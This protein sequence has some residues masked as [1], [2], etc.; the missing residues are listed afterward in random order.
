MSELGCLVT[1]L[2]RLAFG[3]LA[4]RWCIVPTSLGSSGMRPRPEVILSRRGCSV[5]YRIVSCRPRTHHAVHCMAS[6]LGTAPWLSELDCLVTTVPVWLLKTLH[7]GASSP[8]SLGSS[9]MRPRPELIH[10]R[11]GCSL[12]C[13]ADL[14]RITPSIAWLARWGPHR[15]CRSLIVS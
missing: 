10:S 8:P 1:I 11:R 12:S 9:G 6:T 14:A 5:S 4:A 3:N 2:P 15:G 13:R 7:T